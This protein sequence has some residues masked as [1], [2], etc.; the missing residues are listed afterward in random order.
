MKKGVILCIACCVTLAVNSLHFREKK[1]TGK[2]KVADVLTRLGAAP[3][4]HQPDLSVI[5]A[6][7]ERGAELVLQGVTVGP[8]GKRTS[9]QSKNF[10]CTSC[11]NVQRE[12]PD[13]RSPDPEARLEYVHKKGIPFLPATALYGVIN[14]RSFYNGDYQKKYGDLVY[15][16]RNDLREAIQL[17]AVE[18]AQGRPLL[19]WELES[20]LAYLW[21]IGL[22]LGDLG[23][24]Q[25]QLQDIES[26][27]QRGEPRA[28]LVELIRGRYRTDSPA[29]FVKPPE[30][31]QLGY[32]EV[33]GNAERG[34]LIYD[35]ACLHC[36]AP[37]QYTFFKLDDSRFSFQHLDKHIPRYTRYSIYQVIRFGTSPM[38]GK[39]TYMPNFTLQKMSDQQVEDLRAYI[40]QRAN[41]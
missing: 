1:P 4:P 17:C 12:D 22:E 32:T 15:K 11:H 37:G 24:S 39:R 35:L 18:C 36:H 6:S 31:R 5:G 34:Q 27:L 40:Q 30:D 38:A 8:D 10:V 7:V 16:A 28:D 2:E 19:D 25:A 20:V 9:R 23:L 41:E 13:L 29:T 3:A 21:T 14:R 33:E 26:A